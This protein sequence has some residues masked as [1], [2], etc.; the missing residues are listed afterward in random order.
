MMGRTERAGVVHEQVAV[1]H[2]PDTQVVRRRV[3]RNEPRTAR[4]AEIMRLAVGAA[5]YD[6]EQA[7]GAAE[8]AHI[9]RK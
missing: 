7:I 1:E 2:R 9:M 8:A 5:P 3:G 4:H 6:L